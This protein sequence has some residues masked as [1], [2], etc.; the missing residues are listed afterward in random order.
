MKKNINEWEQKFIK[1]HNTLLK[2]YLKWEITL[3]QIKKEFEKL[4]WFK[5]MFFQWK[6]K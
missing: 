6:I 2:K 4:A 1:I 3:W 5:T